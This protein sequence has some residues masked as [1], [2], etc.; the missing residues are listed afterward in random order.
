MKK[1]KVILFIVICVLYYC[2]P[3]NTEI[4]EPPEPVEQI[5]KTFGGTGTEE[6]MSIMQVADGGFVIFG[7]TE[8]S[9]AGGQDFYLLKINSNCDLLWEKKYGGT[10]N[11]LG[12]AAVKTVD[13]GFILAG[14]SNSFGGSVDVLLIRVD[15]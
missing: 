5:G 8:S 9:T 1:L 2:D 6:T 13:N 4:P 10:G 3:G 7:Y 14:N 15:A 11:D 12:L